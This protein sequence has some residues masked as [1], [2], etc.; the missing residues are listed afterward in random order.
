MH[1]SAHLH[2]L[3][4][5]SRPSPCPCHHV[6]H[7]RAMHRAVNFA[8]LTLGVRAGRELGCEAAAPCFWHR[9]AS[10]PPSSRVLPA[11][12]TSSLVPSYESPSTR[13]PHPRGAARP[14]PLP[15]PLPAPRP[16]PAPCAPLPAPCA[17]LPAPCAPLPPCA[18]FRYASASSSLSSRQLAPI[19][20]R[21]RMR[22]LSTLGLLVAQQPPARTAAGERGGGLSGGV[23]RAEA[24]LRT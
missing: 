23:R 14:K 16:L 13:A 18:S 1:A 5:P 19:Y 9:L 8:V 10:D 20:G 6:M 7:Q 4:S 24:H 12:P 11:E 22:A 2:V 15:L 17:P 21:G 3:Q